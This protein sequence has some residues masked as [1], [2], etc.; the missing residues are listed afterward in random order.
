MKFVERRRGKNDCE[1][2]QTNIASPN[3]FEACELS[4]SVALYHKNGVCQLHLPT[5]A[6]VSQLHQTYP[7]GGGTCE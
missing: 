3:D 5:I 6:A 7:V 4:L 1:D 2:A